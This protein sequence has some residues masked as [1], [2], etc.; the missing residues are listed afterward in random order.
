VANAAFQAGLLIE[1]VGPKDEVLKILP[2]LVIEEAELQQG[3][4]VLE[5][6]LARTLDGGL[7]GSWRGDPAAVPVSPGLA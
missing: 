5:E 1:P 6:A 4:D 7:V 2:P 3:L